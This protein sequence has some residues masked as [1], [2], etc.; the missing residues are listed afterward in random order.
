M[1]T[2]SPSKRFTRFTGNADGALDA[3]D[4]APFGYLVLDHEWRYAYSNE[5]GAALGSKRVDE[6][7]GQRIWDVFPELIGTVFWDVYHRVMESRVSEERVEYSVPSDRWFRM[8]VF[9]TSIGIGAVFDD[10]TVSRRSELALRDSEARL[11]AVLDAFASGVWDY[12]VANDTLLV[13]PKGLEILG[14]SPTATPTRAEVFALINSDDRRGFASLLDVENPASAR[15]TIEYR[16]NRADTGDERWCRTFGGT[17]PGPRGD[18]RRSLGTILDVTDDVRSRA[19]VVELRRQLEEAQRLA[20]IGSWSWDVRS[21][22]VV[23]SPETYRLLGF[24]PSTVP[25]FELVLSTAVD[26]AQRDRFLAQVQDAMA[27]TRP[28]EFVASIRRKNGELRVLQN[29]GTVER[30]ADGT[31]IRMTGVFKDITAANIAEAERESLLRQF[32][33]TQKLESLGL[34]AG[35]IAHDFNNLLVGILTNASVLLED[36]GAEHPMR[37]ALLDIQHAGTR[38]SELTRQLLAYSGRARFVVEP[39]NLSALAQ[40]MSQLMKT[41]LAPGTRLN[42][43]IAPEL[44]LVRADPTQILQVVMNLITNAS[45]ALEGRSGEITLRTA[46]VPPTDR[47]PGASRYGE[48]PA[49]QL[50]VVLEVT[51]SGK[52]MTQDTLDRIFEPFFTTKFTGHGLGLAAC[53]GIMR[54]HGGA[55]EVMTSLGTGTTFRLAFS[56]MEGTAASALVSAAAGGPATADVSRNAERLVLV[57]DDDASVSRVLQRAVQRLGYRAVLADNGVAALDLIR[58]GPMPAMVMLDLTMPGMSGRDVLRALTIEWPDLP[59]VLMSGYNEL[60]ISATTKEL[61][62]AGFLNKPFTSEELGRMLAQVCP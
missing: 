14:F 26:D 62:P 10:V 32:L 21:G 51:D 27:G 1:S 31:P 58:S 16:I 13:S 43:E 34:M 57:V 25:S 40:D 17:L 11:R 56:P 42:I 36:V 9:P 55:I 35:G 41:V 37:A 23:W 52:G 3:L 61:K 59:V 48:L 53:L 24:E 7:L 4:R 6:L 19:A 2:P 29:H 44:P 18:A 46:V 60:E 39:V 33:Q 50:K 15:Y 8:S 5:A 49:D 45:D 12:D 20:E 47:L 38:A 28:F 30:D 22:E 54:G